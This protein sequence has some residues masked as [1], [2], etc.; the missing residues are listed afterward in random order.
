MIEIIMFHI[1][2]NISH[3]SL[4]RLL[5]KLYVLM[6]NLAKKLFSK[7][8]KMQSVNLLKQYFKNMIV[9]QKNCKK[10]F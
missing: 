2:N 10:T 5:T 8:E 1:K 7:E 4:A 3:I 6:I 9:A